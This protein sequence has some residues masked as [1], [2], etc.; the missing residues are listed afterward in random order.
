MTAYV[1][2]EYFICLVKLSC[3]IVSFLSVTTIIGE[4]I[5]I[6]LWRQIIWQYARMVRDN[7]KH[8][9]DQATATPRHDNI[10]TA[11]IRTHFLSRWLYLILLAALT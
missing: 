5:K 2:C 4:N 3:F 7:S 8:V 1:M 6:A 9:Y 11:L 10:S